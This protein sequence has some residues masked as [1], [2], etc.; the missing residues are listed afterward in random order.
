MKK[1]FFIL[2]TF[3][4]FINSS[5]VYGN[6]DPAFDSPIRVGLFYDNTAMPVYKLNCQGGFVLGFK[7]E[8]D[9]KQIVAIDDNNLEVSRINAEEFV[10][11]K[12]NLG[13]MQKARNILDN[14]TAQNKNGY[15]F[16]DGNWS[17]WIK[18]QESSSKDTE[19][20]IAVN[21]PTLKLILPVS[22]ES[23][24]YLSP[25][26]GQ[27][28]I[29][30]N[31]RRYRGLIE[32][33]PS[34]NNKITAVNELEMEDYL[35]GVVPL[36]MPPNWPLEALKAQA[37]A[38]RTYALY[39][40]SKWEKF[41]F[42]ISAST[43]DQAYEGYEAENIMTNKAVDETKEQYILYDGRPIMALYHA[44][45]GGITED[46][47][48]VFGIDIPYLKPVEDSFGKDSPYSTWEA[49]FSLKDISEKIGKTDAS[50]GEIQ[51]I[52]VIE[53]TSSGRVKEI[54]IQGTSANKIL[55]GSEIRNLLQL[56]SSLFYI[57]G[58]DASLF[59][60]SGGNDKQNI[61]LKKRA[62]ISRKGL[63]SVPD[64]G[65]FVA[66]ES[67]IKQISAGGD[68]YEFYGR[69]WGH[70]VGMSQWGARGMAEEGYNYKQILQHY[71]KNVEIK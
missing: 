65:A 15:I 44:D 1:N 21:T 35:Y 52:S 18:D 9:F 40:L 48:D 45:S 8:R 10:P 39:N 20:Y 19:N 22:M 64:Q 41:G 23:P 68:N 17:V 25:R 31:G 34:V 61:S 58:G 69:G 42:D 71:Y 53:K 62:I 47:K 63:F 66:G 33:L 24:V 38:S 56:K 36:E 27:E 49:S 16:Y 7:H 12:E 5:P 4:I 32:I 30:L 57:Q 3:L 59:I 70:G 11:A 67:G 43:V 50:V 6:E 14:L 2:F 26:T 51:G 54:M 13:S 46:G 29:S 55:S 60:I 37:V 28:I